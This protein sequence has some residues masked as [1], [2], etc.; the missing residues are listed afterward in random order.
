M[1]EQDRMRQLNESL[2][3]DAKQIDE[4]G[5]WNNAGGSPKSPPEALVIILEIVI[6]LA[7]AGGMQ[8]VSWLLGKI[9]N[10]DFGKWFRSKFHNLLKGGIS[11]EQIEAFYI[12]LEKKNPK[13]IKLI[14]SNTNRREISKNMKQAGIEGMEDKDAEYI[15]DII[16]RLKAYHRKN[17]STKRTAPK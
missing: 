6:K 9:G 11:D 7:I 8:G 4:K 16:A 1:N 13:I 5:G 17:R 12:A 10:V 3:P 2:N 14:Q 15:N